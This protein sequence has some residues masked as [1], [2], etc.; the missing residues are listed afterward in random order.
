MDARRFDILTR[1]L[2]E[3]SSRRS[4]LGLLGII[5]AAPLA[6]AAGARRRPKPEGPCGDF[7]RKD[8]ICAKNGDCCTNICNTDVGKTN[9]DGKGRCRCVRR[10]RACT[11]DRNCCRGRGQ[12]MTCNPVL[13][14][15]GG[16]AATEK[17]CGLAAPP[18][19]T[20]QPSTA[21]PTPPL[22]TPTPTPQPP[23]PTPTPTPEPT[24]GPDTCPL[25]CCVD[26]D[27]CLVY[28][29][30]DEEACGTGGQS[31]FECAVGFDCLSGF[32]VGA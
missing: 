2:G 26:D 20:T 28:D 27:E 30:Q 5:T 1:A 6:V 23:T 8:N 11:E 21:T 10:G 29:G 12:Q 32:C 4:V 19:P 14:P 9:Q 3:G 24:C 31:C 18:D 25:G 16:K 15:V 7:S 17:V 22:L 13:T